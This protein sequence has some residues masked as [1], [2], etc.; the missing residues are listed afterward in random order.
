MNYPILKFDGGTLKWPMESI[1]EVLTQ[2]EIDQLLS[3]LNAG[4]SDTDF[5]TEEPYRSKYRIHAEIIENNKGS[6]TSR[7]YRYN[8]GRLMCVLDIPNDI[9]KKMRK[10][11]Y[12]YN[13]NGNVQYVEDNVLR[14]ISEYVFKENI[15][16]KIVV[17][18][19]E[20]LYEYYTIFYE[21]GK[22]T[23]Q[24]VFSSSDELKYELIFKYDDVGKRVLTLKDNEFHC[25]REYGHGGLLHKTHLR[26]GE[27]VC[28][29][30][31]F[32]QTTFDYDMFFGC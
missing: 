1:V 15:L 29:I 27:T 22:K 14:K 16:E 30:W 8:G 10:I 25:I 32:G 4:N 31:E 11:N 21:N 9:N 3:A 20:N 5:L 12:L 23:K 18:K 28:Y 13:K 2:D 6:K 24:Y 19:N 7:I 26:S 17:Y